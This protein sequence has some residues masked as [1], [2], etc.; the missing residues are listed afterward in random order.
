[1]SHRSRH[2]RSRRLNV[3]ALTVLGLLLVCALPGVVGLKYLQEQRGQRAFLREARALLAK[4]QPALALSYVNKFLQSNPRDVEALTLKGD[5]LYDDAMALSD[6][7][8]QRAQ[9]Q[10]TEAAQV[11]A[12]LVSIDPEGKGRD[13]TRR[14]LVRLN[15]RINLRAQVAEQLAR[16]LIENRKQLD[17]ETLR[18]HARSLEQWSTYEMSPKTAR[19]LVDKARKE[20][21]EAERQAPGDVDGARML[22]GLYQI[23]LQD[24][25]AALDVLN[26]VVAATESDPRRHAQ[27]LRARYEHHVRV[28][29]LTETPPAAR[30]KALKSAQADIEQA[31]RESPSDVSVLL[32]AIDFSLARRDLAA[33]RR[34]LNAV[35]AD[36]ARDLRVRTRAGQIELAEQRGD[37]AVRTWRT[38]LLETGGTDAELTWLLA[39]VLL[40]LRRFDQAMPLIE[41]YR[42]L[43]GGEDPGPRYRFLKG[44]A[45]L[46]TNKPREA[47]AELE[48][49]RYTGDR[50][51]KASAPGGDLESRIVIQPLI[52][53]V[54]GL[55]Y[56]AVGERAKAL[57]AY[58]EAA[59]MS[60]DWSQPWAAAANLQKDDR[61]EDAVATLRRGLALNPADPR[62]LSDLAQML[63]REQMKKPAAQRSW[64]EVER[65]FAE[66]DRVAPGSPEVAIVRADYYASTDRWEDAIGLLESAARARPQA[67]ELWLAL[68]NGAIQRGQYGRALS[69]LEQA[70]AGAGPKAEFYVRKATVYAMQGEVAKS[71]DALTEGLARA[72][73]DQRPTLWKE[74]GDLYRVRRD[75]PSA[76][77]AYEEW[78]KLR[79]EEPAPRLG[80]AQIAMESGDEAAIA[81]AVEGV[82]Q[83]GGDYWRFARVEDLLRER[84]GEKPDAKRDEGRRREAASLIAEIEAHSPQNKIAY[85]LEGRLREREGK[86]D[87]AV[88]A[89]RKALKL[90]AGADALRPLVALLVREKRDDDLEALRASLPAAQAT[91]MER[92]AATE[93][94]RTGN[95]SQAE[96]LVEMA[97]R[98]NPQGVDVRVW[99]AEVLRSLGKPKEAEAALRKA[100]EAK[101]EDPAAWVQLVMLYANTGQ[102]AQAAATIELMKPKLTKLP[103]PDLLFAQCYRATG[104]LPRAVESYRD[105]LRKHPNDPDV[106]MSAVVFFQQAGLRDDAEQTLRAILRRA[107]GNRW[108]VRQLAQSLA[109]HV[110]DQAAWEEALKLIGP[111][112]GPDDVPDDLLARARVY[113]TGPSVAHRKKAV[114]ILDGLLKELPE[115]VTAQETVA[116]LL[117]LDGRP[118]DA[119]PHAARAAAG[120]QAAPSAI[121]LY[122]GLLRATRKLDEADAQ[123]DRIAKID[124]E[125]LPLAEQRARVLVD[126]GKPKEAG[127]V[128]EKAFNA[129]PV[130][131]ETPFI[132]KE[133]ARL[134][135]L[136][137]QTEAAD[138]VAQKVSGMSTWGRTARAEQLVNDGKLDEAARELTEVAKAGDPD[139]AGASALALAVAPKA[140]P[141]WLDLADKFLGDATKAAPANTVL[142]EKLALV[143]HLQGRFSEEV[144]LYRK[145]FESNP[146]GFEFLNNMAWT[147]AVEMGQ[148]DEG[149]KAADLAVKRAGPRAA[150]LDT[151]GVI[152]TRMKNYDQAIRD[153]ETATQE[154]PA[155]M[156]LYHLAVAYQKAGRDADARRARDR[157]KQAGIAR[158]QLQKSE[159]GDWDAVMKL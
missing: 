60:S 5:L 140:D 97:V 49:V 137:G 42:R 16:E 152:H 22:A 55:S 101:P 12:S 61:P 19:E 113:E 38:G 148:L 74:L 99:Q 1:M 28:G 36:A 105:A 65:L 6:A 64:S 138:R 69:V 96:R 157:A 44:L 72:P 25:A 103:Y 17:A 155:G 143:R 24:P 43:V 8:V 26:R 115:L 30:E 54:L 53:Y 125:G 67:S 133:V 13:E 29:Q 149:L 107:P 18:L 31:L 106:L 92:L 32:S 80:L 136:W 91:E 151:R 45:L 78:V 120:E 159:L 109:S 3:R 56:E 135:R 141:R 23:R 112:R 35:P 117:D 146:R 81:K 124:P 34:Y 84:A 20:Y 89:Y 127:E 94:I 14:R 121:L 47:I 154:A 129:R 134:L 33:A 83:V 15:L 139:A 62:L 90:D 66:A 70:T 76:R 102:P 82:R 79:P 4:K 110:N 11:L 57:E 123:L 104:N 50:R 144:E 40:D 63:W 75:Y 153:L 119:L 68:A 9:P 2:S 7:D 59:S 131:A 85:V 114:A 86:I 132:G 118:Q 37:E 93:A 21:Q 98:G 87:E 108:A 122:A 58:Q 116:R 46:R 142:T 156:F 51:A 71:R 39:R 10:L 100:V 52:L 95:K 73:V 77:A 88:T 145:I 147:L 27:A 128:L 150:I 48:P 41:Q 111:E 158:E 130:A 126:R